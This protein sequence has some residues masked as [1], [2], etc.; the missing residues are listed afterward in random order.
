MIGRIR[1][2]VEKYAFSQSAVDVNGD[3]CNK[4]YIDMDNWLKSIKQRIR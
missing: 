2:I 4:I 1:S 3:L